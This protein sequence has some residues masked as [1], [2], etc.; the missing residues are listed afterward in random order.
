M[1]AADESLQA[2]LKEVSDLQLRV[3]ELG[4]ENRDLRECLREICSENGIW[5]EERLA[6][7][8]HKRYFAQLCV[9]HPV[10]SEAR[11]TDVLGAA[12]VVRGIAGCA[13][14]VLPTGLISRCFFTAFTQLTAQLPWMFGCRLSATYDIRTERRDVSVKCHIWRHDVSVRCIAA[15]G[16]GRLASGSDDRTIKIWDL[17]TGAQR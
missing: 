15:L 16:N 6:V 17:S 13:G 1:S 7:T 5:C 12:P 3:K 8:R 10:E 4:E 11:A 2:L 9:E 14:S